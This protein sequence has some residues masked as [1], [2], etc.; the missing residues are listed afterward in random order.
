MGGA[1]EETTADYDCDV[2]VDRCAV[3]VVVV[4]VAAGWTAA[5]AVSLV[6]TAVTMI[7]QRF[8]AVDV[9]VWCG[10]VGHDCLTLAAGSHRI[11]V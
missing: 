6:R 2:V 11:V 4:V 7:I 1:S 9:V 3:V 8:D 5:A 10:S